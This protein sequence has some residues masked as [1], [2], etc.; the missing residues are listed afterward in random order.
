MNEP[1]SDV[2]SVVK[3]TKSRIGAIRVLALSVAET[4]HFGVAFAVND[5]IEGEGD[6]YQ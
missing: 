6:E 3:L 5:R 4:V 1:A 2:S